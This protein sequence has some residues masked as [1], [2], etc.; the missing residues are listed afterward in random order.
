MTLLGAEQWTPAPW[1]N[2]IANKNEF[3][4][5][6]TE[7]GAGYTWS[8]NSRENRLT[9]WSNDAVSDP[10]GEIV[11]LRDEDTGTVWS[12]TPLPIR[13][14]ESHIIRHGQ[15]YSVFDLTETARPPA[16]AALLTFKPVADVAV[17]ASTRKAGFVAPFRPTREGRRRRRRDRV[18]RRGQGRGDRR[19]ACRAEGVRRERAA[20]EREARPGRDA[21]R[22]GDQRVPGLH[23][24]DG[25]G[26]ADRLFPEHSGVVVEDS[27]RRTAA[28]RGRP[29]RSRRS[30]RVTLQSDQRAGLSVHGRRRFASAAFVTDSPSAVTSRHLT[31]ALICQALPHH[32]AGAGVR[33]NRDAGDREAVA[34]ARRVV[35]LA[36][37]R[38]GRRLAHQRSVAAGRLT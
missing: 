17:L 15:G 8:V 34:G 18:G 25:L 38:V 13:G 2:I 29:D 23:R 33:R 32:R 24:D 21:D 16:A 6:V 9:P 3:G 31:S 37:H 35:G 14:T 27:R 26:A 10:P 36:G 1:S 11:Y 20:A 5:Q 4:F 7:T 19:G 12:A 28:D 22:R 30:P